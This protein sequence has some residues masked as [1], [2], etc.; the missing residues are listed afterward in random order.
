[1][2]ERLR[3]HFTQ[4]TAPRRSIFTGIDFTSNMYFCVRGDKLKGFVADTAECIKREISS[5][6]S[7]VH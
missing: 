2:R 5:D 6:T 3:R 7:P 1:M 4:Y